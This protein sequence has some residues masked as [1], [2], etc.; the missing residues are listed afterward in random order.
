MQYRCSSVAV[1]SAPVTRFMLYHSS[2]FA[3]CPHTHSQ[4]LFLLSL[5]IL[6][7]PPPPP[8]TVHCHLCQS[9][10]SPDRTCPVCLQRL[11]NT[12]EQLADIRTTAQ[13]WRRVLVTLEVA[14]VQTV[15]SCRISPS[16]RR[17]VPVGTPHY[18]QCQC[19]PLLPRL[20][21]APQN[22]FRYSIEQ[23]AVT[24]LAPRNLRWLVDFWNVCAPAYR[25]LFYIVPEDGNFFAQQSDIVRDIPWQLRMCETQ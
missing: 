4:L 7:P 14:L 22:K 24:V 19:S 6:P 20:C 23:G 3:L 21:P 13:W 5:P 17:G 10:C 11:C 18:S 1:L 9:A 8:P 25:V 12:A 16:G 2:C 15:Q